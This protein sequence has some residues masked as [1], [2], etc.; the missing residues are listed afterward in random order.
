MTPFEEARQQLCER[1]A[2]LGTESVALSGSDGRVT[3][4]AVVSD[5]DLPPFDNSAMDGFSL[6]SGQACGAGAEVDVTGEQAAGD[7]QRRA[8]AGSWEVM[9]GARMPEG[10]DTVVP[11]ENVEVVA[12]SR[13][14]RPARIRLLAGPRPGQHV[15]L[16]GQDIAAGEVAVPAGRW[17]DPS[18]AMLL[19]GIGVARVEV[20][21]RP[22]VALLCTGRELVDAPETAL[23]GGQIYNTNGPFLARRLALAGADVVVNR[24]IPD[25]PE[26]F[27]EAVRQCQ[28]TGV[29][30]VVST[31]AVSMGRY[32]FVPGVLHAMGASLVFHKVG[33]RPGKPLLAAVLPSGEICVGLPGNP[34]SSAVGERFFV[35]PVIRR[36]LGLPDEQPWRL[37]LAAGV[38]KKPA[39]TMIQKAALELGPGG[40]V[41]VRL[42]AGQE[43]FRTR[44]LLDSR[45]WALLPA[46]VA[47]L[48]A[49]DLVDVHPLG[50]SDTNLFQ[51][52]QT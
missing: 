39:L 14:G 51:R 25:D 24:T 44:P 21:R 13:D 4:C 22:R 15:R 28:A 16:R 9:T 29:D 18:V 32:D 7:S 11:V 40:Q 33:M 1:A 36:M 2:P 38:E 52:S 17:I 5:M 35:E 20:R 37:P 27:A 48:A 23:G 47:T 10:F 43:S 45:A 41:R 8:G 12:R 6:A 3:A 42:L 34:V 46:G 50:H 19:G 31:G 49:G 30:L 26:A